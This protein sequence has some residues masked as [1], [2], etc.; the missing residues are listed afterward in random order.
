M[1]AHRKHQHT[2]AHT[3]TTIAAKSTEQENKI[4]NRENQIA[5]AKLPKE[6]ANSNKEKR[7][8]EGISIFKTPIYIIEHKSHFYI[9]L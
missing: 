2:P 4:S 7:D 9:I 8:I 1:P 3:P 5:F 6:T